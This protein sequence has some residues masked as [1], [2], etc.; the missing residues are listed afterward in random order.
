MQSELPEDKF[1]DLNKDQKY[2]Y[3]ITMAFISGKCSDDLSNRSPGKMSHARWLAKANRILQL[4]ISTSNPSNELKLLVEYCVKIYASV[5]FRTKTNPTCKDGSKNF[6]KLFKYSRYLPAQL[7][8][9]LGPLI[10]RNAYFAHPEHLLLSM[11]CDEH[12]TRNLQP[13]NLCPD[14]KVNKI[15]WSKHNQLDFFLQ[16]INV[17]QYQI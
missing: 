9:T 8:L 15:L 17:Y 5:W 4:Y 11:L 7:K 14:F 6:W 13:E 10:Q 1:E 16:Y 12:K 2:L 3:E